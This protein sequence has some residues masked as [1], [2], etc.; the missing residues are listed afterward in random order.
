MTLDFVPQLIGLSPLQASDGGVVNVNDNRPPAINLPP[1][2][3]LKRLVDFF[4]ALLGTIVLLPAFLVLSALVLIDVGSPVMFWQQ[5]LGH[6]GR[7]F[8]LYKFRTLRSPFDWRG[9]PVPEEE[10]LSWIGHLI[11]KS[12]LDELP[13]LFNVLVGDMSLIGPRPLLPTDQP[14]NPTV[15]LSVRPGI[16]GW[17]QVNGGNLVSTA[18]K[19]A[20]DEWY[21]RHASPWLDLTILWLTLRFLFTGERRSELAVAQATASQE[22]NPL[23]NPPALAPHFGVPRVKPAATKA[24]AAKSRSVSQNGIRRADNLQA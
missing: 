4:V 18:E 3:K 9:N 8:L 13:Q 2:F 10:R 11:R 5:R 19:C 23:Q 12:R 14:S 21:L 1:Y 7:N 15:R 6:G 20:L 17:A 22:A 16:T 24:L